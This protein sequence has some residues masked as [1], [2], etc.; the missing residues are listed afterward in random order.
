MLRS[1]EVD[2]DL[3]PFTTLIYIGLIEGSKHASPSQRGRVDADSTVSDRFEGKI[4]HVILH[5]IMVRK[6]NELPHKANG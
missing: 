4:I 6:S 1:S 3:L 5:S 2:I